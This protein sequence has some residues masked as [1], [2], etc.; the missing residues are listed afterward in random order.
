VCCRAHFGHCVLLFVVKNLSF[1]DMWLE[2][3]IEIEHARNG[4]DDGNGDQE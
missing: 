2:A 1:S 3:F 4:I